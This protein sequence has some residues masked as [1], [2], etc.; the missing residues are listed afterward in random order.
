MN[1]VQGLKCLFCETAYPVRVGY[2]CPR[3]GIGGILDVQYDYA[4]IRRIL[5]RTFVTGGLV[6]GLY[7]LIQ[8]FYLPEWDVYWLEN[9]GMD[10]QGLPFPGLIRVF[11]TMNSL[12]NF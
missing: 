5:T 6:M 1:F 11:S 4:A 2:T 9:A 3:C 7:G 8:F 10:S 12:H